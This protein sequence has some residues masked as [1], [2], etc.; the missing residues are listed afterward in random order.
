MIKGWQNP[1]DESR[2]NGGTSLKEVCHS[3]LQQ[4]TTPQAAFRTLTNA[5]Q[6]QFE[7]NRGFLA[8]REEDQARFL[9]VARFTDT[10]ALKAL[11]LRIPG[12]N[13]VFEKVAEDGG[14]YVENF[15]QLFEG[16]TI[17]NRLLIGENT[18]SFVLRPLKNAGRLVGLLGYSSDTTD[19]F[20]TFEDGILD[21]VI[22]CLVS[23]IAAQRQKVKP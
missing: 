8:L 3:L 21:P 11:S 14:L 4:E 15:V 10:G 20:V 16:N 12:I 6:R 17:E 5:L 22:D 19:A 23:V 18:E 9:A 7:I 13:S 1:I 2:E